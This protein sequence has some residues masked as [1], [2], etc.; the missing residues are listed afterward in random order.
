[1]AVDPKKLGAL[2]QKHAQKKMPP[3]KPFGGGGPPKDK[4]QGKHGDDDHHE[5]DHGEDHHHEG[6]EHDEG[7]DAKVAEG[8]AHRVSNGNGD[9]KLGD[10]AAAIEISE[11]GLAPAPDWAGDMDI[12]ERAEKA[13]SSLEDLDEED[14]ASVLVHTYQALGGHIEGHDEEEHE[15]KEHGEG[16]DEGDDEEGSDE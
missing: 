5:E 8:Q 9:D 13:V 7:K 10:L 11:D 14:K 6:G 1:M 2:V 4:N 16:H 12:W 3:K 15:G